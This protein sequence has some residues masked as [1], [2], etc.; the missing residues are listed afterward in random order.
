MSIQ[1]AFDFD[2]VPITCSVQERY[3]AIA[4]VLAGNVSSFE[5][6]KQLNVSYSTV[7][8]WLARFREDGMRGLFPAG[9]FEREPYT[10]EKVVVS[11]L[12]YKSCLLSASY[13]E[14]ARV[15]NKAHKVN[16][17][18]ET[19]KAL[20]DRYFFWRHDEFR[21][22][23]RYP[24]PAT[25]EEKRLEMVRLAKDG[26]S[27]TSIAKLLVTTRKTV[28]KWIRRVRHSAF[29]RG[30]ANRLRNEPLFDLSHA[31]HSPRRKVYF[32]AIHACLQL[33]KRFPAAGWFRV[34]GYLARDY[35][36]ELGQT[37][38]KKIMRLNRQ[39]HLVPPKPVRMVLES[40]EREAPPRSIQPFEHAFIDIRYLDAKPEGTQLYSCLLLE[41][42]SRTILAGSLTRQQD[43]G[44]VLRLYYLALL[45][46]GRW[47]TIVSDHGSQFR[48]DAFALTNKRLG[49]RH[50]LYDKGRPWQSLIESQFGIQA[51]LGEYAWS[52][53]GSIERAVEIHRE[54]IR[55][56][57]RLPHFA[58]HRRE[59]RRH[60]PLEVLA[61]RRGEE[62]A[63]RDLHYAFSRRN[64]QRRTDEHGFVRVGRWRVYV[65]EGLPRT[66]VQILYWNGKLRAEYREQVLSEYAG[67]WSDERRSVIALKP[68]EYFATEYN[69]RQQ[70]LFEVGWQRDP[71]ENTDEKLPRTRRLEDGVQLRLG[72]GEA[73]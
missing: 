61:G 53:C 71:V 33:Q 62:T 20:L 19:V 67:K 52:R 4:P 15:V 28:R 45:Q 41:G 17:H 65:E 18:H 68:G 69:T 24:V 11:L 40:E 49:I 25:I 16:L 7:T 63:A 59:D 58:H 5:R 44:V 36:I 43:L 35:Q 51:R 72:F 8:R 23:V 13:R 46:W 12:F 6:A 29:E 38:I 39:L 70:Q 42:F 22:L 10:P 60:A 66:P 31:P 14:L 26:W 3:H 37:A 57:N 48:A 30:N 1:L 27:E 47:V 9:Q 50:H 55:D 54:L 34:Q 21:R 32:G 2:G 73:A 56:H 64:W